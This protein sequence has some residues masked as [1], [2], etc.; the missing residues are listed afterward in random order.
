MA[1]TLNDYME[2]PYRMEIVEDK[3]E[4]GFVISY[5]DLPGCITCGE[6]IER[7]VA[8]AL[9]AKREWLEAALEEGIEIQEPDSLE[10]YSGQFKLRLPKSLHRLL[11]EH[12]KKEGISMNQYCVYLLAR[13]DAAFFC[14][15]PLTKTAPQFIVDKV[16]G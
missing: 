7:A 9:D 4:G 3:D 13:N 10:N 1:K 5:P 16:Y 15:P 8:N 2:M 6:T 11:A 12:S 14:N